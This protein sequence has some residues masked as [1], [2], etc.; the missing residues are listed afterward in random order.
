VCRDIAC[1]GQVAACFS[2]AQHLGTIQLKGADARVA[3]ASAIDLAC[4][5]R[6]LDLLVDDHA[7]LGFPRAVLESVFWA[8]PGR[9]PRHPFQR[10]QRVRADARPGGRRAAI[11]VRATRPPMTTVSLDIDPLVPRRLVPATVATCS[12]TACERDL[13]LASGTST[14]GTVAMSFQFFNKTRQNIL[15]NPQATAL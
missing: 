7:S 6:C 4:A 10:R 8:R 1:N 12:T 14:P 3:L 11:D 2:P 13:R 15:G 9:P 5:R